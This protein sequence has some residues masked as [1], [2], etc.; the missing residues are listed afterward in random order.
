MYLKS[1]PCYML[2]YLLYYLFKLVHNINNKLPVAVRGNEKIGL[3]LVS[4]ATVPIVCSRRGIL[5]YT[6]FLA[7]A[8]LLIRTILSTTA[9]KLKIFVVRLFSCP[10]NNFTWTVFKRWQ[11]SVCIGLHSGSLHLHDMQ[12]FM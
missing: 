9:T 10:P 2:V 5:V 12:N 8:I 1:Q 7:H 6:V 11:I 3:D 4:K